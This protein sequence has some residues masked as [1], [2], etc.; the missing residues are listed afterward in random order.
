MTTIDDITRLIEQRP[1]L[2][3]IALPADEYRALQREVIGKLCSGPHLDSRRLMRKGIVINGVE[4]V[5][6]SRA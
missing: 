5:K 4:V 1:D 3:L 6:A 2:D